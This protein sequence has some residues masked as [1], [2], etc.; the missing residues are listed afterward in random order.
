MRRSDSSATTK[1]P[2][3]RSPPARLCLSFA[4][5]ATGACDAISRSTRAREKAGTRK[6]TT[7]IV[8]KAAAPVCHRQRVTVLSRCVTTVGAQNPSARN[9]AMSAS[10][11]SIARRPSFNTIAA[12]S[13][14]LMIRHNQNER[15][16]CE[17][18]FFSANMSPGKSAKLTTQVDFK[19]FSVTAPVISVGG[20]ST[21][22]CRR[23]VT[24]V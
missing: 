7:V 20:V 24:T 18:R 2:L 23:F 6:K 4:N 19:R 15:S 16:K 10:V 1:N 5:G 11:T 22:N 12:E 17:A 13:V 3:I 9:Q 21:I 8:A 14:A